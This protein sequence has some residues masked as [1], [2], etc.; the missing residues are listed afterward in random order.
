M[1]V[2]LLY[3]TPTMD[4]PDVY[5]LPSDENGNVET[6]TLIDWLE[7]EWGSCR[8]CAGDSFTLAADD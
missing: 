4:Q 5:K 6:S 7:R 3:R 2:K 1:A 8:L